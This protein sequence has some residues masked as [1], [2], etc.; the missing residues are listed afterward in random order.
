MKNKGFTLL[1]ILI[2]LAILGILSLIIFYTFSGLGKQEA[3]QKDVLLVSSILTEAKTSTLSSKEDSNYGV[4]FE[5]DKIIL[6]KGNNFQ[7]DLNGNVIFKLSNLVEIE[8]IDLFDSS[9]ELVFSRLR[10]TVNN[11]GT[12][13]LSLRDGSNSSQIEILES[14]IVEIK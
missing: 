2:V 13:T 11:Y 4:Y 3:L 14:G 10:G 9:S 6:F 7:E 1:E 8:S 12:I 5:N